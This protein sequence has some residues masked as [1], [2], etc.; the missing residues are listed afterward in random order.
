MYKVCEMCGIEKEA[1][2]KNFYKD[3]KNEDGLRKRCRDCKTPNNYVRKMKRVKAKEGAKWCRKCD[4]EKPHSEFDKN[5]RIKDGLSSWCSSCSREYGKD[6]YNKNKHKKTRNYKKRLQSG[7]VFGMLTVI[8]YVKY[9]GYLCSCECGNTTIVHSVCMLVDKKIVSCGCY[10]KINS[11]KEPGETSYSSLYNTYYWG[12]KSRG[13]DFKLTID[14]LKKIVVNNCHYCNSPP[15]EYN[16]YRGA[17]GKRVKQETIDR[18]TI[19]VNGID[20]LDNNVGYTV[21][22]SVPCCGKCNFMKL[23][24]TVEDFIDHCKKITEN[25]KELERHK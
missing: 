11:L 8:E 16:R 6:K 14:D 5:H 2:G 10:G 1:N 15:R 12:A 9:K 19:Y 17:V 22:N 20:R 18:A 7:S 24:N 4:S 3:S 13:Y 23:D 21:E 25:Q